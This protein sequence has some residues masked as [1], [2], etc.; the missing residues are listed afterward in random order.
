MTLKRLWQLAVGASSKAA[1]FSEHYDFAGEISPAIVLKLLIER[2]DNIIAMHKALV[3]MDKFHPQHPSRL[4][5]M[6]ALER[7]KDLWPTDIDN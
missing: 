1:E 4:I 6:S 5:L 3:A 2:Q 7:S